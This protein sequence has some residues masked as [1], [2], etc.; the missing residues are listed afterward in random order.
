MNLSYTFLHKST[1]TTKGDWEDQKIAL[2]ESAWMSRT[3]EREVRKSSTQVMEAKLTHNT[4]VTWKRFTSASTAH[5]FP[6][7]FYWQSLRNRYC[8]IGIGTK[9][10]LSMTKL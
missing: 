9:K 3:T 1:A 10:L 8:F 6:K 7:A 5:K 4:P 2:G